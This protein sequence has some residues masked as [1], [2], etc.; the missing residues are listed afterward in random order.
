MTQQPSRPSN[1]PSF[2]H[3][4][5]PMYGWALDSHKRPVPISLAGRGAQGYTCP[6]CNGPMIAKKGDIKQ[7]HFAHEFESLPECTPENVAKKIAGTW[8][9]LE[10]G[11]HMA[12]KKP[13]PLQWQMY[14]ESYRVNLLKDITAIQEHIEFGKTEADIAL[15]QGEKWDHPYAV[16]MLNLD[17]KRDPLIYTQFTAQSIPVISL[18]SDQFRSGQVTL[19]SVLEAAEVY[20]GWWLLEESERLPERLENDPNTIRQI[21]GRSVVQPP[22]RFWG[23]LVSLYGQHHVLRVGANL[24]WLPPEL[25][26]IAV[27]GT[28]NRMS[29]DLIIT[30]QEWPQK[31]GSVIALYYVNLRNTDFAVAIRR[32]RSGEDV[33]A[34]LPA[35][36][37]MRRTTAEEVAR[38]LIAN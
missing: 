4:D 19:K 26:Q 7:H 24:V 3:Q 38:A 17:S 20:G 35:Q 16:F 36:Y 25:W 18:P 27:G 14:G 31:D 8:L 6:I 34:N 15:M 28:R 30:T 21:L 23:P 10:L 2:S 1:L 12:H 9:V 32:F 11:E 37:R 5:Q 13:F 29:E 33:R 22:Y